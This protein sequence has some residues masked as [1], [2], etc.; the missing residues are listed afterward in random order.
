M[1]LSIL[2]VNYG[3]RYPGDY[4]KFQGQILEQT[5]QTDTE[6]LKPLFVKTGV[7]PNKSELKTD[8]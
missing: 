8:S 6:D 7:I 3:K 4:C 5:D 1:V 2:I